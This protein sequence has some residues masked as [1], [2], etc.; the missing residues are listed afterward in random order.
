MLG[1]LLDS[2]A[3]SL[4]QGEQVLDG[5][6]GRRDTKRA[7]KGRDSDSDRSGVSAA[8]HRLAFGAQKLTGVDVDVPPYDQISSIETVVVFRSGSRVHVK[9]TPDGQDGERVPEVVKG[10]PRAGNS[11]ATPLSPAERQAASIPGYWLG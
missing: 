8:T 6:P 5:A 9:W 3:G 4:E 11:G 2:E 10:H 7:A 1:K